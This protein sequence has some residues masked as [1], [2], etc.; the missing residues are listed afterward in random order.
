MQ[1]KLKFII[2]LLIIFVLCALLWRELFSASTRD[3]PSTLLGENLPAFSLTNLNAPQY[4]FTAHDLPHEPVLLNV[5]ASWCEACVLEVPMLLE[6]NH[7]YKVKIYS[8]NYKDDPQDAK[9]WLKKYGNPFV[10]TGSDL[11]GDA[12]IDLGVYGTPETFII[13]PQG[14]IVYRH[15]GPITEKNW[16]EILYPLVKHYAEITH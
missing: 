11:N 12:A 13:S 14:K 16:Q 4:V 3:L 1:Q 7:D 6:I 10:I 2:P 15:L 9:N 5:W 8:I